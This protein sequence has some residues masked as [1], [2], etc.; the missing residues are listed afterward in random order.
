M[1]L[2]LLAA[3]ATFGLTGCG[4]MDT[5]MGTGSAEP[6]QPSPEL[7]S[8]LDNAER[9]STLLTERFDRT[10]DDVKDTQT[11]IK[12]LSRE[13]LGLKDQ[14]MA[15][16][17]AAKA[18]TAGV[19]DW[20]KLL[21]D[22]GAFGAKA[23]DTTAELGDRIRRLEGTKDA[24]LAAG[25]EIKIAVKSAFAEFQQKK[26]QR[27]EEKGSPLSPMELVALIAGIA[28]PGSAAIGYPIAR[29]FRRRFSNPNPA[30]PPPPAPAGSA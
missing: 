17:A 4:M 1:K 20:M 25:T 16:I 19:G 21:G 13:F 8:Q 23:S 30:A 12:D 22:L 14:V 2:I 3:I 6:Y 5:M 29:A 10:I 28:I 27:E 7:Q 15:T 26:Q 9:S 24:G 18:G 11:E